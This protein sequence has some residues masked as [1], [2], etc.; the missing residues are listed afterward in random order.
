MIR[1]IYR[2]IT[3]IPSDVWELALQDLDKW[4]HEVQF[5]RLNSEDYGRDYFGEVTEW[6]DFT[7]EHLAVR[8]ESYMARL[9]EKYQQ[10]LKENTK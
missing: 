1:T 4:N 6:A 10:Q 7:A 5:A 2:V 8:C 3:D 9:V